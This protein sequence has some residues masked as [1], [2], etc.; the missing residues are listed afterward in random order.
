MIRIN[1]KSETAMTKESALT[2][3]AHYGTTLVAVPCRDTMPTATA[4]S[5]AATVKAGYDVVFSTGGG[6][7]N[8]RNEILRAANDQGYR[9]VLM[10]DSDMVWVPEHVKELVAYAE[11]EKKE[12]V[13]GRYYSRSS[14]H[15]P[16]A[17]RGGKPHLGTPTR[18][19]S[20]LVDYTGAGFLYIST[21][22]C[23]KIPEPWFDHSVK[24]G[25]DA[26]FCH[27]AAQEGVY[28][29]LY[30]YVTVGHVGTTMFS[31]PYYQEVL[32]GA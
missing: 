9:A 22:V 13:S 23:E 14:P 28:T 30:A 5:I 15:Q 16:H 7:P 25:E 4:K 19:E 32:R 21:S 1:T 29:W 27:K 2:K 3:Q 11:T 18:G 26:Y 10:V 12:I 8:A 6:L 17:Y 20:E 31:D 24:Q